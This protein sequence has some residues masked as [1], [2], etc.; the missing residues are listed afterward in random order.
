LRKYLSLAP[1]AESVEERFAFDLLSISSVEDHA[2]CNVQTLV[3]LK[4]VR[5]MLMLVTVLVSPGMVIY[6]DEVYLR[7]QL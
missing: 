4:I 6:P 2:N 5:E 1:G 7:C 3:K